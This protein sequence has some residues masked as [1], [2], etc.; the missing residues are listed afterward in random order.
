MFNRTK[1]TQFTIKA[2]IANI[3]IITNT[4]HILL[5]AVMAEGLFFIEIKFLKSFKFFRSSVSLRPTE[6]YIIIPVRLLLAKYS[7][8]SY[9]TT[10][11]VRFFERFSSVVL[12]TYIASIFR[13][14]P[15]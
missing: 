1:S 14:I 9:F 2:T 8:Y 5:I 10:F 6:A 13:G 3:I 12:L 15:L 7:F 11:D 4:K